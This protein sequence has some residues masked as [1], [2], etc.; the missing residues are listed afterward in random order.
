[1]IYLLLMPIVRSWKFLSGLLISIWKKV[2]AGRAMIIVGLGV[3][4]LK[5]GL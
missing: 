3:F 5:L 4:F 2:L 1:M